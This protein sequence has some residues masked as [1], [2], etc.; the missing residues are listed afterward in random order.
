MIAPLY[1]SA[2]F[3]SDG[4][5]N[6]FSLTNGVFRKESQVEFATG[7]SPPSVFTPAYNA[8]FP[9]KTAGGPIVEEKS[10]P[11]TGPSTAVYEENHKPHV[12]LLQA[13]ITR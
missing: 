13:V 5:I 1:W 2:A 7:E 3:P 6:G 9:C 8:T 10:R 12:S 4:T 11:L